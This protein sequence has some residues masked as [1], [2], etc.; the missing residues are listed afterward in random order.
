VAGFPY[1]REARGIQRTGEVF[2][3]VRISV[4]VELVDRTYLRNDRRGRD[5]ADAWKKD[6]NDTRAHTVESLGLMLVG[7]AK[8]GAGTW[9]IAFNVDIG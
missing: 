9:D 6:Y 3:V 1:F 7:L 8:N 5:L 2:C 4:S